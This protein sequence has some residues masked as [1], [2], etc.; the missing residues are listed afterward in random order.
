MAW[1]ESHDEIWDH[2]KTVRLCEIL[3]EKDY[4]V[5]GRLMSLWHFVLRNA[6]RDANLE[7]W[8][9]SGIERAA[10]WEFE[11]GKLVRALREVGVLD[12]Y[13]AHGWLKRAGRLVN[14][15][16]RN[17]DRKLISLSP[18]IQR[19]TEDVRIPDVER[20]FNGRVSVATL[21]YPTL[22]NPTK[23][24]G[25]WITPP[26]SSLKIPKTAKE[27]PPFPLDAVLVLWNEIIDT[28]LPR[29]EIMNKKR[30]GVLRE[31]LRSLPTQR[32]WRDLFERI[33]N[34]SFLTGKTG[35]FK[36]TFDWVIDSANMT[37]ILEGNYDDAEK[38]RK[39]T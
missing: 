1:I 30:E 14:D 21:P 10:R 20:T 35:K 23:D 18:Q 27:T 26:P 32:E 3:G 5:V 31:R 11:P 33:N 17:E 6:W 16:R 2:H 28:A 37:K 7:P 39:R 34:S 15:R 13:I 36:A 9:D 25:L 24:K 12:G 38:H 22:P 4:V 8:G 19:R 29:V